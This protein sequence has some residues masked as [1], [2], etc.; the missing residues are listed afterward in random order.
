MDNKRGNFLSVHI[1]HMSQLLQ[2]KKENTYLKS[3]VVT[4]E[5]CV[6]ESEDRIRFSETRVTYKFE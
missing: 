4:S 5:N 2:L 3:D 1:Y 6:R